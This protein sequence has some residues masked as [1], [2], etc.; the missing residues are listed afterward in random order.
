MKFYDISLPISPSMPVWPGDPPVELTQVTSIPGGDSANISH[1]NMG[2]HCGTH[3]DA[4]KHFI[5]TGKTID[6]IPLEKLIGKVLVLEIDASVEVISENVLKAHPAHDLLVNSS[7]VI[8]KTHNSELWEQNP[9]V[10]QEKFVAINTLGATYLSQL[11]LDLIGIDYLSIAPY[12]ETIQP[13]LSLLSNEIVLL[14]G[15][16]L[17]G[18]PGGVYDLFCLPLNLKGCDGSPARVILIG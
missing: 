11:N 15:L 16:K 18:V 12:D 10:F 1:I 13:H 7:K 17:S 2:V 9:E 4:P 5:D 3:I 14:E 8:F 6:Q